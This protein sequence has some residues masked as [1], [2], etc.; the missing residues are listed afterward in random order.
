M[1]DK[2]EKHMMY[3]GDKAVMAK[4]YQEHL[5]LK[6]KGYNH[7]KPKKSPLKQM[8]S[9]LVQAYTNAK[10][11]EAA[12]YAS[13][14]GFDTLMNISNDLVSGLHARA[15][16]K[17]QIEKAAEEKT[18]GIV[19]ECLATGGALGE[20]TFNSCYPHTED[21]QKQYIEAVKNNDKKAQATIMQQLNEFSVGVGGLKE[22]NQDVALA[23]D[24]KDLSANISPSSPEYLKLQAFLN[25]ETTQ[26][27]DPETKS[28]I[29]T[30]QIPTG[31]NDENGE[32]IMEEVEFSNS[33]IQN[34]LKENTTDSKSIADIRDLIIQAGDEAITQ[35]R[36]G[37]L[38]DDYDAVRTTSKMN[39]IIKKGNLNSLLYDDVLEDG[40]SFAQNIADNPEIE[41]MTYESLGITMNNGVLEIDTDGDGKVDSSFQDDGDGKISAEEK[42]TL[43]S[44]GFKD[45]IIDALINPK[46][47]NFDEER[48]RGIMATYFS[49]A[50]G[51]QYRSKKD[52]KRTTGQYD[53]L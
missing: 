20:N 31:E 3:K 38:E 1:K 7:T 22:L 10:M 21:L 6:K 4:T 17:K 14:R 27:Y 13:S 18:D 49:A 35:N 24:Q 32:P 26:R 50:V 41:N 28:F 23:L 36:S 47:D 2:F 29:Y 44:S 19:Q 39:T 52:K 30:S 11:S 12:N 51:K 42:Q 8:D 5:D 45:Q 34:I 53:D 37:Y 16:Q 46:N 25:K 33:D 48:T 40:G 15:A 9:G 43:L